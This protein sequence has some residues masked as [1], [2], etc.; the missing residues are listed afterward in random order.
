[1]ACLVSAAL[2]ALVL[3]LAFENWDF[4]QKG[5]VWIWILVPSLIYIWLF[6][7]EKLGKKD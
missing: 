4:L 1:L 3:V 2:A 6:I 5:Y 7:E